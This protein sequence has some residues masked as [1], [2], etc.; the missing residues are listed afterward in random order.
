MAK[1]RACAVEF[2][3]TARQ[4]RKADFICQPCNREAKKEWRAKRKSSGRP[5]VSTKMPRE[6]HQKYERRYFADPVNRKR[7]AENQQRY[8]KNPLLRDRYSARWL[9][10][11][12]IKT[13]RLVRGLCEVCGAGEVEAHHDD[14]AKPLS[15]RWLCKKHHCEHH[16]KTQKPHT[17]TRG[18]S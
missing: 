3:P 7:V 14:Y 6:W 17:S 15:I 9:T 12:A 5:V 10:S 4:I 11:R 8:R 13:G 1:C 18:D 2:S 16:A